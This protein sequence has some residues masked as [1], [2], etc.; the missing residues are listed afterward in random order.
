V[1]N[2][3][4]HKSR[5]GEN[6]GV[7]KKNIEAILHLL[8]SI[9][10]ILKTFDKKFMPKGP[11]SLTTREVVKRE[12]EEAEEKKTAPSIKEKDQSKTPPPLL[13]CIGNLLR[14]I[15][16]CSINQAAE[17]LSKALDATV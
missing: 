2:K 7:L 10:R 8:K 14:Q 5:K 3:R 11:R 15:D 1:V 9:C 16:K 13:N 17:F 4:A 6:A 12:E